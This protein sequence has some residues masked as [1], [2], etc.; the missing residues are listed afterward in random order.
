MVKKKAQIHKEKEKREGQHRE[1]SALLLSSSL[2][3]KKNPKSVK[4]LEK[5]GISITFLENREEERTVDTAAENTNRRGEQRISKKP[6]KQKHTNRGE[7][8]ERRRK[9]EFSGSA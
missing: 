4:N 5:T 1:E 3:K 7:E 9:R 2:Q 8:T 6:N